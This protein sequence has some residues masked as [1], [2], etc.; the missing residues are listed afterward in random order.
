M[1]GRDGPADGSVW[2]AFGASE[3]RPRRVGRSRNEAGGERGE[4]MLG[5][6][7]ASDRGRAD[8]LVRYKYAQSGLLFQ[9]I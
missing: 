5:G 9:M 7:I 8:F 4:V 2:D 1:Q 3:E 6:F